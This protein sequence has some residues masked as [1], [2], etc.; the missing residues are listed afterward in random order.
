MRLGGQ[1]HASQQVSK[2]SRIASFRL[3]PEGQILS[4]YILLLPFRLMNYSKLNLIEVEYGIRKDLFSIDYNLM[5]N[6]KIF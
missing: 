6:T 4:D 3:A 2:M 1:V 5:K